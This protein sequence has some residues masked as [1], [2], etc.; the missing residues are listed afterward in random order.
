MKIL[1]IR[2]S[3]LG[4]LVTLEPALRAIRYFY[5][6][7]EITFLSSPVGI[8]LYKDTGYFDKFI[9]HGS[10]LSSIVKLRDKYDLTLNL[11]CNKPSH[12]VAHLI[13]SGRIVNISHNLLQRLFGLPPVAKT[14][15]KFFEL[16][17][18]DSQRAKDY[19]EKSDADLIR[20]PVRQD[21]KLPEYT[22]KLIGIST[23]SS[24]RWESKKWGKG[25]YLSLVR[26]LKD[27]GFS[28]VLIGS[29]LE[30]EDAKFITEK[31]NQVL[32][33][34]GKTG[35]EELKALISR[36]DVYIGNDSGPAHIAA[37]VGC[38]TITLFGSTGLR[39]CVQNMNYAGK[40][41]CLGPGKEVKCHPCYLS[42]CPTQ[43]ECM[44]AISVD[45]V[46]DSVDTL[47]EK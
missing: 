8:S 1:V 43:H 23:G 22:G 14:W 42:K 4:D 26:G 7:D 32:D 30:K 12:F 47:L 5:P 2:F 35:L 37:A 29:E 10:V 19:W 24:P 36:L 31:V 27:R 21:F 28:V 15:P 34:T 20:L 33:Y 39:H 45:R 46:L 44:Q 3:S 40:H 9:E 6:H 11:Q 18:V 38:K 41:I 25:R 16:A 13:S 17:G